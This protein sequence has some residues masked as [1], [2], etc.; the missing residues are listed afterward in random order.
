MA[1]PQ[2][3]KE[4]TQ[5]WRSLTLLNSW[6]GSAEYRIQD[7][8]THIRGLVL[9]GTLTDGTAL[10]TLPEEARLSGP[11]T[12]PIVP[13]DDDAMTAAAARLEVQADGDAVIYGAAGAASLS[14]AVSFF[15][16]GA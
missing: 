11:L 16:A 4:G 15:V 2:A 1:L 14:L 5:G 3:D 7:G 6:T 9:P 8:Q 12:F 13:A 10:F